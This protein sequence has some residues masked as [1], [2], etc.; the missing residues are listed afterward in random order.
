MWDG[1][2]NIDSSPPPTNLNHPDSKFHRANMGPTW[3]LSSPGGP[4]VGPMNLAVWL[5]S[6]NCNWISHTHSLTYIIMCLYFVIYA[7]GLKWHGSLKPSLGEDRVRSIT[8]NQCYYC[9]W[10]GVTRSQVIN[11]NGIELIL[12]GPNMPHDSGLCIRRLKM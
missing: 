8:H 5:T 2:A 12:Q 9:W 10:V 7:T 6:S 4:H 11:T 3:V 1:L